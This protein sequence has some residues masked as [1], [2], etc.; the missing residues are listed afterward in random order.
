[1]DKL[2]LNEMGLYHVV[3]V[4]N[5]ALSKAS[6]GQSSTQSRSSTSSSNGFS[7]SSSS[8]TTGTRLAYLD[9][10]VQL[11][12]GCSRIVLAL[13]GDA[14]GQATAQ[15]IAEGLGR[16][17]CWRVDW[18]KAGG[19]KDANEVLVAQGPDGLKKLLLKHT[20]RCSV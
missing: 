12:S 4:P 1:M 2:S 5:G 11:L 13:D 7:T 9:D 14:A 19:A 3:S 20:V 10:A 16:E 15:V 18:S 8:S 17:R 6:I